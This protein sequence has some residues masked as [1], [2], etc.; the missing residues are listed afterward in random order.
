M[1]WTFKPECSDCK[2]CE[3][4]QCTHPHYMYCEHCELWTPK[5]NDNAV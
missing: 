4:A 1:N 3:D 2:Y 5:E